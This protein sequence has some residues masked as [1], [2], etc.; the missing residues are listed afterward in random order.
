[1]Q[2][3]GKRMYLPLDD[4]AKRRLVERDDIVTAVGILRAEGFGTDELLREMTKLFYVDLDEYNDVIS[5]VG[6][7]RPV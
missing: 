4:H 1:M 6:R 7:Y 5:T 2:L 3:R